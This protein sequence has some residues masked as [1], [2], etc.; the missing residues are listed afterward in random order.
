MKHPTAGI[1]QSTN[2]TSIYKKVVT[3]L[4]FMDADPITRV[5]YTSCSNCE[6]YPI[7]GAVYRCVICSQYKPNFDLCAHCRALHPDNHTFL[8]LRYVFRN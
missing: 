6:G 1:R 7:Y 8:E 4:L 3:K 5:H 2:S